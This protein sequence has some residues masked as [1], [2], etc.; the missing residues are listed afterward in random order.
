[1]ELFDTSFV[2]L[3][4]A[5]AGA[6][7]RQQVLANNLANAN[8]PGYRRLDVDFHSTLARAMGQAASPQD[9]H[10]VGFSATE[11]PSGATRADGSSVDIDREM[12]SLN[13]NAIEY[14]AL[15]ATIRAQ[16]RLLQTVITGG[17]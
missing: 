12:A 10:R 3:E 11:D 4:R 13:E 6:S 7:L 9:L 5:V 15:I 17:R 2:A 1:M 8:T 14:Q 16:T